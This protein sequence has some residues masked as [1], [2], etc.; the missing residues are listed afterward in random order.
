[1]NT[2]F[3][4]GEE[5]KAKLTFTKYG[6]CHVLTLTEVKGLSAIPQAWVIAHRMGPP[7]GALRRPRNAEL[8]D[9]GFAVNRQNQ[10]KMLAHFQRRFHN[11]GTA[12]VRSE[13]APRNAR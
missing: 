9:G 11:G 1:M 12:I 8:V 6:W 5:E 2:C 13:S 7:D 4:P 3:L 10:P